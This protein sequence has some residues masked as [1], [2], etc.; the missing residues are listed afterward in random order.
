MMKHKL[1]K[2]SAP[3]WEKEF[4]SKIE[5]QAELFKYIC[6]QC[7]CEEGVTE[8]SDIGDMLFTACGCEFAVE[9]GDE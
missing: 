6:F 5:L 7:Q 9:F 1:F 4:E 2:L 8:I 3:G